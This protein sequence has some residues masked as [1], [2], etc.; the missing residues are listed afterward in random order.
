MTTVIANPPSGH[1]QKLIAEM[2]RSLPGDPS[3]R[4]RPLRNKRH[5]EQRAVENAIS[6]CSRGGMHETLDYLWVCCNRVEC[7]VL[8]T[9]TEE[10]PAQREDAHTSGR[11]VSAKSGPN[12]NYGIGI[13][14]TQYERRG[15]T[16]KSGKGFQHREKEA[17][18]GFSTWMRLVFA[19]KPLFKLP[20][21]FLY[22]PN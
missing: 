8:L 11:A 12:V 16:R 9:G 13:T 22:R 15:Q 3:Y 14:E 18:L 7:E 4:T 1:S 5:T 19:N 20:G 17:Q 2:A 10:V 6:T 21:V